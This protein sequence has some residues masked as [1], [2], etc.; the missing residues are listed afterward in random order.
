MIYSNVYADSPVKVRDHCHIN[1]KYRV[2][3]H[4]DCNIN[5]KLN[6]KI[7][8]VFQNL[9]NYYLNLTVRELGR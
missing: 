1:G 4:W 7:S 3:A 8:F 5:V 6:H 2:S 9:I